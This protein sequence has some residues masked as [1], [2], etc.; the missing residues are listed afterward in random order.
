MCDAYNR[1]YGTAFVPVMPTNLYGPPERII[2]K[3]VQFV[4]QSIG[5]KVHVTDF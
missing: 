5:I 1:Q 3:F 2:V 4:V